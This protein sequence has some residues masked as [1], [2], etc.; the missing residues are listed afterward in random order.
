MF[1]MRMPAAL[2]ASVFT[3]FFVFASAVFADGILIPPPDIPLREAFEIKYHRV[4]V[5]IEDGVAVTKVDQAFLNL[6]GRRIE[7]D[8]VFPVPKGAVLQD[9]AMWVGDTRVTG[10]VL[11]AGEAREIY[12]NIV[13]SQRDP[14][15]LEY[16]GNNAF[17]ARVF[18]IEPGEEKR[19]Q[20]S[21]SEV[22]KGDGGLYEYIYPLNTEKFSAK[23]L[24]EVT[25][26]GTIESS[27]PIKTVYSPSH[28]IGITRKEDRRATFGYEERN[29]KPEIDFVLYYAVRTG[30]VGAS[31]LAFDEDDADDGFFISTIA[32]QVSADTSKVIA[33]NF[34]FV[35]DKSGSM[36]DNDK[37]NQ[38]KEALRFVV[39]NLNEGD[40]FNVIAYSDEIW[41]CFPGGMKSYS[42]STRDEALEFVR[43]FD[44]MGGTDINGSLLRALDMLKGES[45]ERPSYIIFL[46]D[47]LPTVG[48]TSEDRIVSNV[49]E[50]NKSNVRMFNFGVGYDVNTR[51]LD[52]LADGNHGF[53]EYVRPG[54]DMEVKVSSFFSKISSPML[55]DVKIKFNGVT[56][57]EMY[58][59]TM[60]DLFKGSQVVLS[61]R[62]RG[63]GSGATVEI[64]G[65]VEGKPRTFSF[66]ANFTGK[67]SHSFVP[68]IWASRKIAYLTDEVNTGGSKQELIDEIVRLSKRYGIITEYT[69]FLIRE[70][71][72]FLPEFESRMAY[73]A[74]AAPLA[75]MNTGAGGVGQSQ[76]A[77]K[78]KG[79]AP[80]ANQGG[81]NAPT[82]YYDKDGEEVR[83]ERIKYIESLTF[84]LIDGFWTDSRYDPDKF[85]T[86]EVKAFSD[87]YYDILARN[88]QLGKF[89]ALG[90]KL[91]ICIDG[92]NALKIGTEGGLETMSADEISSMG[93]QISSTG[94]SGGGSLA[95]NA[96][97]GGAA[98]NVNKTG[99]GPNS[100]L[101]AMLTLA[102]AALIGYRALLFK[103]C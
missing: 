77:Q 76:Q 44:A 26:T 10:Q 96:G 91:I 89:F 95:V 50:A 57:S 58:P 25:I 100:V 22:V 53:S 28:N 64:S 9:F 78:M 75:D 60:P 35:L 56:V 72:F 70:D 68:R 63:A 73:E 23:P 5:D 4:T 27:T 93:V 47:G 61:G 1:N 38:A 48:E 7:A 103:P 37:I 74:A 59:K 52:K 102:A 40:R 17:R 16:I 62:F 66:P 24:G 39:R 92:K 34:I 15:L 79:N 43:K 98:G 82:T 32:P 3:V 88:P 20:L 67:S 33:K 80:D 31:V 101:L 6:T 29:V 83:V 14:A 45:R 85:K 36:L 2:A 71:D 41:E 12:E 46:T 86:K 90:D 19:I 49:R 42:S 13:R 21:Y 87:A 51:L 11:N 54:E 18:P 8:Y 81:V 94:D 84:F 65:N 97:I 69:S 99:G 55:T 30:E